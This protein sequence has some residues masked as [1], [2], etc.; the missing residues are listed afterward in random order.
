MQPWSTRGPRSLIAPESMTALTKTIASF[1]S[2]HLL[3]GNAPK[4]L[5]EMRMSSPHFDSKGALPTHHGVFM[6]EVFLGVTFGAVCFAPAI[7]VTLHTTGR[8]L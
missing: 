8:L 3:M 6:K 2:K 5:N 4:K 7:L 1:L